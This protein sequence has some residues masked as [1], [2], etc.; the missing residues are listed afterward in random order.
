MY[1]VFSVA[2]K[3]K[4]QEVSD[5]ES[6]AAGG[7]KKEGKRVGREEEKREVSSLQKHT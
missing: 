1:S 4:V 7:R 6:E 3:L 2:S 5:G